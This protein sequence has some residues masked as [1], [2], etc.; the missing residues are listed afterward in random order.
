[1]VATASATVAALPPI[2]I[3]FAALPI[4]ISISALLH[5][6]DVITYDMLLDAIAD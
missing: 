5:A 1:M 6:T 2:V 4:A 3:S